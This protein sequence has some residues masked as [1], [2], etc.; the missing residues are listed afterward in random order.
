MLSL[1]GLYVSHLSSPR[2]CLAFSLFSCVFCWRRVLHFNEVQYIYP[3]LFWLLHC[4]HSLRS[5]AYEDIF[6]MFF[7][8]CLLLLFYL[9]R[10][11]LQSLSIKF[12]SVTWERV[13][14]RVSSTWI[15]KWPSTTYRKNQLSPI[16]FQQHDSLATLSVALLLDSILFIGLF[17]V[18]HTNI[19][20]LEI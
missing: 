12:V 8:G 6:P 13:T 5:F 1:V 10:L 7:S 17:V 16:K 19:K 3:F 20:L 15:S 18:L 2:M 9:S 4:A 11:G 14:I